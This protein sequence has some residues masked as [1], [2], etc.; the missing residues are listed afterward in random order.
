M[1]IGPGGPLFGSGGFYE[2]AG[3]RG[4]WMGC[5]CSSLLMIIAGIILVM[6][7]CL[8]MLGQ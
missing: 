6:S 1:S 2:P 4:P 5:G 8:R 3:P 7:G